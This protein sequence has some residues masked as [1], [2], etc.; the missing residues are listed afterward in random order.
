MRILS[1]EISEWMSTWGPLVVC[2]CSRPPPPSQSLH[3][4]FSPAYRDTSHRYLIQVFPDQVKSLMWSSSG[5]VQ[6]NHSKIWIGSV[7]HCVHSFIIYVLLW[8]M[9]NF[10]I[11]SHDFAMPPNQH[12]KIL[13]LANI[14]SQP[15]IIV[16][17]HTPISFLPISHEINTM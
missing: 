15:H 12:S 9:Q 17:L 2:A 7:G 10:Q 1:F 5:H 14:S 3:N 16:P 6:V 4:N 8:E 13:D 11:R